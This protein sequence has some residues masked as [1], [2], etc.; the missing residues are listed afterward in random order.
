MGWGTM[1]QGE[2]E[3]DSIASIIYMASWSIP[4]LSK[5]QKGRLAQAESLVAEVLGE[6]EKARGAR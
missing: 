5:D 1:T 4:E 6:L 3:L 2:R